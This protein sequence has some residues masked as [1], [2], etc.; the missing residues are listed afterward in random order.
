MEILR[1]LNRANRIEG[2]EVQDYR[3]WEGGFYYRLK[4]SFDNQTV[5]FVK[6]Y[7]DETERVYSYHWQDS[8]NEMITRWDNAP[9]HRHLSTFPHHRHTSEGISENF[10][11]T[12][13]DVLETIRLQLS[14]N[15]KQTGNE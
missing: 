15:P 11:I 6:E 13:A 7:V 10:E 8:N 14:N 3:Q 4:I 1:L 9:H 12:L 5:L 2:Y